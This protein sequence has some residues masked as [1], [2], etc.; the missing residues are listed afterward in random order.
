MFNGTPAFGYRIASI[1]V[2]PNQ[3]RV[4]GPADSL[5]TLSSVNTAAVDVSG[6]TQDSTIPIGL[7]LPAGVRS[8]TTRVEVRIRVERSD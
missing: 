4:M 6:I 8:D 1:E 3:I 2:V 5:E 7:A